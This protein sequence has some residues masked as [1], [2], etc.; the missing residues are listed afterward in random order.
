MF[1]LRP[2]FALYFS[3]CVD[4]FPT[5]V[6]RL[7]EQQMALRCAAA[8]SPISACVASGWL[9]KLDGWFSTVGLFVGSDELDNASRAAAA[10][11]AA[12]SLRS[13]GPTDFEDDNGGENEDE[14][15]VKQASVIERAAASRRLPSARGKLLGPRRAA[16]C[17]RG[18]LRALRLPPQKRQPRTRFPSE[19]RTRMRSPEN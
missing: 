17:R 18:L 6:R 8:C 4:H 16:K 19:T 14:A 1:D 13:N 2:C 9:C 5:Q 7:V 15:F 12:A 11:A 10:A 3:C